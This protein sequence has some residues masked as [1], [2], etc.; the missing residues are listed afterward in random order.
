M[1]T[2]GVPTASI[3]E[4]GSLP[5]GVS[6]VDN[7]NGTATLSGTPATGT[8][9]TYPITIVASNGATPN[10]SQSFTLKVTSAPAITSPSST[11]F[12]AGS[13]GNFTVTSTGNPT[14]SLSESGT[15]PSGVSFIDNGDGTGT[16]SGTPA[17]GTGGSY[18]ISFGASNGVGSPASQSFLLTVDESPT[19]TS[20]T[21]A[22]F[23]E[24]IHSTYTVVT[25]GNPTAA[26][27]ES[28]ALPSGVTFTDN[29]DGTASLAGTPAPGTVGSYPVTFTASNGIGSDATQSFTLNVSST[30]FAPT[31]TSADAT[32]F[33]EGSSGT[34]AVTT[35]GEPSAQ[36]SEAGALP[37]GVAFIDNGDGT[38]TLS[39]TP[40]GQGTYPITIDATNGVGPDATQSFTLT[41]DASPVITS[42]AGTDF[43]TGTAGTFT[44]TSTGF[45]TASLSAI[46]SLPPGVTFTDNGDGTA[47]LSGTPAATSS[48]TYP[49]SIDA[50][51][52]VGPDATQSFTLSVDAVPVITS[53]A[54][55]TFST[56]GAGSFTVTSTGNP[57]ATLSETGS[58][59]S[60]V[61]FVD[62][63]DGTGTLSGTP[64]AGTGGTYPITFGA[65]NGVGG[66]VSQAFTLARRRAA[67]HH[68]E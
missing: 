29:G 58:L 23:A 6:F 53:A 26:V 38:A 24:T 30:A 65:T 43:V 40:T 19:F 5:S 54:Q 25:T 44:V 55:A 3:T 1:T 45:P 31:I 27:S 4:T 20:G 49:I 2:T 18:P 39:G 15:L 56:A 7:G 17:A 51:N 67:L 64:A 28:G 35:I 36:I 60:G 48:G 11:T 52:G 62:N 42:A 41:V 34:F 8:N 12:T 50:T 14:D 33:Q 61:S 46:G 9:G 66:P 13:P 21:A 57:T 32:T 16:L 68:V 37:G 10:A 22:S 59:P 47:T 63:G